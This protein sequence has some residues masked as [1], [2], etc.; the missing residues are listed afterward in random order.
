A[1]G[2]RM[3][4]DS[5][6]ARLRFKEA[7][8][9]LELLRQTG[10]EDTTFY[11]ALGNA[12]LLADDVPGA[13]LAYRKGLQL[14]PRDPVLQENL[15]Y[16]RSLVPHAEKPAVMQFPPSSWPRWLPRVTSPYVLVTIAIFYCLGL[17]L[18]SY[19]WQQ[20]SRWLLFLAPAIVLCAFIA[21][22]MMWYGA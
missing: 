1:E 8:H 4:P 10:P 21:I 17:G 13:I 18:F 3:Q 20:H 22:A 7:V 2:L 12:S 6:Q 16:A 9:D 5:A 14:S 11:L 19:G 15:A